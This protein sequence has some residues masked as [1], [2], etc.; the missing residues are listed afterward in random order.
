M[1]QTVIDWSQAFATWIAGDGLPLANYSITGATTNP[2]PGTWAN[3]VA[4]YI[5]ADYDLTHRGVARSLKGRSANSVG[6]IAD[7]AGG[8]ANTVYHDDGSSI[9]CRAVSTVIDHIGTRVL[10]TSS[11][12]LTITN[13]A[14]VTDLLAYTIPAN[15][16]S[17][18][19]II[20]VRMGG[21][22]LNNSAATRAPVFAVTLPGGTIIQATGASLAAN[23]NPSSWTLEF[24]L[25]A[26]SSTLVHLR[27]NMRLTAA[28]VPT[29]GVGNIDASGAL[30]IDGQVGTVAAGVTVSALTSNRL[31]SV[32]FNHPTNTA[33]QTLVRTHYSVELL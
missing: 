18:G 4:S 16:L 5:A 29:V 1:S 8:G 19:R 9:A 14:T 15:T 25:A 33:T 20:R 2:S 31:L 6:V 7:I 13:D 27:M 26:E 3:L 32:N 21:T 30:R 12:P 11:T 10:A 28:I 24:D 22:Y 17:A 23:A